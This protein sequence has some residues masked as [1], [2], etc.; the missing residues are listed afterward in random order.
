VKPRRGAS[1]SQRVTRTA[2]ADFEVTVVVSSKSWLT[3]RSRRPAHSFARAF[4][5]QKLNMEQ[6]NALTPFAI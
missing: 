2:D 4:A 1:A 6:A 3:A 5:L